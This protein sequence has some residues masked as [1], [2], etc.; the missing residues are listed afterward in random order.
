ML[1]GRPCLSRSAATRAKSVR[2]ALDYMTDG[3]GD[4]VSIAGIC[5]AT[6]ASWRTL[7]RGFRERFGI[8]PKAYL[9]RFR[10]GQVRSELLQGRADTGVADAA[11]EW[12][13]WHMGQFAKDYR[14]MFGELPSETLKTRSADVANA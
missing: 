1:G 5:A 10:L 6:G 7:D 8:G 2:L 14:K 3:A 13:F 4:G 12:G 11:N 9:N